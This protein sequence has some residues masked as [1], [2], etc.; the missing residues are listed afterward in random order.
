[1]DEQITTQEVQGRVELLRAVMKL[2]VAMNDLD[3]IEFEKKYFKYQFKVKAKKWTLALQVFTEK[4]MK[5]LVEI[6]SNLLYNVYNA[7]EDNGIRIS[8]K[9]QERIHLVMFY[10]KIKS[11]FADLEEIENRLIVFPAEILYKFTKDLITE[12]EKQF[13]FL[14]NLEDETGKNIKDLIKHYNEAGRKILHHGEDR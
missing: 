9:K 5:S 8:D 1:M 4:L 2:S 11:A 3:T 7:F 12:M 14:K 10:V 6:D 13:F